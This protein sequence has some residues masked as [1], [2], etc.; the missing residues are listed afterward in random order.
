MTGA[1]GRALLALPVCL[2]GFVAVVSRGAGVRLVGLVHV[3]VV[4]P[5]AEDRDRGVDVGLFVG[6]RAAGFLI[7]AVFVGP[8]LVLAALLAAVAMPTLA[9]TT[10]ARA[11][12]AG[13]VAAAC[14]GGSPLA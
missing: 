9:V 14:A 5:I 13:A 2:L 4:R 7:G 3:T 8:G 1:L 10:T 11:V 6:G 12:V